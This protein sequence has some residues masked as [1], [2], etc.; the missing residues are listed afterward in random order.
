MSTDRSDGS[1]GRRL[2]AI[3]SD[4]HLKTLLKTED[5]LSNEPKFGDS[6]IFDYQDFKDPRYGSEKDVARLDHDFRELNFNVYSKYRDLTR[7][8]TLDVLKQAARRANK[9]HK[10]FVCCFLTHGNLGR[11]QMKDGSIEINE[12]LKCFSRSACQNLAG[13]PKIFIFQACRGSCREDGVSCSVNGAFYDPTDSGPVIDVPDS[14]DFLLVYSTYDGTV[15]YRTNE[16]KKHGSF[17]IDELCRSIEQFSGDLD[18]LQILT[19]AHFRVAHLFV[20]KIDKKKQMP[21]F[22]SSL[23]TKV[24]FNKNIPMFESPD[25]KYFD[26]R[27]MGT[28]LGLKSTEKPIAD[29]KTYKIGGG[30]NIKFLLLFNTENNFPNCLVD[31]LC[32]VY[33]SARGYEREQFPNW[34]EGELMNLLEQVAAQRCSDIDCLICFITCQSKD[35]R[36]YDTR[37]RPFHMRKI[38]EKFTGNVCSSLRGKPKIFIFLMSSPTQQSSVSADSTDCMYE[39]LIPVHSDILE[40]IITVQDARKFKKSLDK[41]ISKIF[42]KMKFSEDF[43]DSF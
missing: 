11:L 41:K 20:T 40:V 15:A 37:G 26:I 10:C 4:Q 33:G 24:K 18:L 6:Y 23:T 22:T 30:W 17:F 35:D 38:V 12:I 19:I 42:W 39:N 32:T 16:E 2:S 5:Q 1:S 21:C 8:Q 31:K 7:Q 36:L 13:I 43:S 14:L 27:R 28:G 29:M 34:T 25:T 3:F 9:D